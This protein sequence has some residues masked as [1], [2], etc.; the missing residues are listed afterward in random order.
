MW[1]CYFAFGH[2]LNKV[3]RVTYRNVSLSS[4]SLTKPTECRDKR[5]ATD[6][7]VHEFMMFEIW[8]QNKTRY[9]TNASA[10]DGLKGI[11][12]QRVFLKGFL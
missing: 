2:V 11:P 5:L 6:P 4:R 9:L 1:R 8:H 7:V 10:G 3:K 12:E